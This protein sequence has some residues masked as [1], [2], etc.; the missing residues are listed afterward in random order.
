MSTET[1]IEVFQNHPQAFSVCRTDHNIKKYAVE[2]ASPIH[3]SIRSK[4]DQK[5]FSGFT[6]KSAEIP[7]EIRNASIRDGSAFH[8]GRTYASFSIRIAHNAK[9]ISTIM[10]KAKFLPVINGKKSALE[11]IKGMRVATHRR[12]IMAFRR[13]ESDVIARL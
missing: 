5:A 13:K 12:T 10:R 6:A 8:F 9:E 7:A 3:P 2:C 11:T 1:A 4:L